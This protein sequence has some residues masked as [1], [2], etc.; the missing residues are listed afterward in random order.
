MPIKSSNV[1]KFR[2]KNYE[3]LSKI[4]E[5]IEPQIIGNTNSESDV[6]SDLMKSSK[7][8]LSQLKEMQTMQFQ[9]L[10]VK[11]DGW[12][13]EIKSKM[14]YRVYYHRFYSQPFVKITL[15]SRGI[16]IN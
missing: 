15:L 9:E 2:N 11:Y 6:I 8:F 16:W 10:I 14:K 12:V 13:C 1:S 7:C 3:I 5:E 4:I